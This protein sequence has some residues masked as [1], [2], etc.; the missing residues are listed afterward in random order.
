MG[1]ANVASIGNHEY[2]YKTCHTIAKYEYEWQNGYLFAILI[3]R[4]LRISHPCTTIVCI[5]SWDTTD[6]VASLQ[7]AFDMAEHYLELPQLLEASDMVMCKP[8]E[9]SVLTYVS[10]FYQQYNRVVKSSMLQQPTLFCCSKHAQE[11]LL[12]FADVTIVV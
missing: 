5:R 3:W 4:I 7:R 10:Y 11:Y 8:D 2:V 6:K 9:L 1:T 12:C